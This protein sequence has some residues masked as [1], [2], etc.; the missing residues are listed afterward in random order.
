MSNIKHLVVVI[1]TNLSQLQRS[2][3]FKVNA[4]SLDDA[5]Q[6]QKKLVNDIKTGNFENE[7]IWREKQRKAVK[8]TMQDPNLVLTIIVEE[9]KAV[10]IEQ[11][12]A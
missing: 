1:K 11:V 5:I 12:E 6:T 8:E 4:T 9:T 7:T 3:L 2:R 10:A